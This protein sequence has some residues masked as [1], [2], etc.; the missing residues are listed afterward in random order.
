MDES[1]RR[2]VRVAGCDLG[3]A[4]AKLV[5]LSVEGDRVRIESR[6]SRARRPAGPGSRRLVSTDIARCD[7][8][9][10]TAF[11]RTSCARPSSADCPKMRA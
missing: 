1:N 11:T 9:G 6:H 5:V 3:K 10:A 2:P 7:A 4:A 8:L